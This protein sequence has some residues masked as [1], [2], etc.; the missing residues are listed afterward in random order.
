[1][2]TKHNEADAATLTKT[3]LHALPNLNAIRALKLTFARYTI[4][5]I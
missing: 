3:C 5:S 4:N 1:M 2:L